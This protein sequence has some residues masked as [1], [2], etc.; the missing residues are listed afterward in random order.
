MAFLD[1]GLGEKSDLVPPTGKRAR[2]PAG[3]MDANRTE[4]RDGVNRT[5]PVDKAAAGNAAMARW[6][7]GRAKPPTGP[8]PDGLVDLSDEGETDEQAEA[9]EQERQ[10]AL[11]RGDC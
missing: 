2:P 10:Q 5:F 9:S 7:Q 3:A 1:L 11:E 8:K 4:I 6:F